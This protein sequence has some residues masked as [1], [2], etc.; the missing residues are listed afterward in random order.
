LLT[1]IACGADDAAAPGRKR[2]D[3]GKFAATRAGAV[4]SGDGLAVDERH[5]LRAKR[6]VRAKLARR[7]R[8]LVME[9]VE[10]VQIPRRGSG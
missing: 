4:A 6:A 5:A 2:H 8:E 9:V 1:T 7:R 10:K 3:D